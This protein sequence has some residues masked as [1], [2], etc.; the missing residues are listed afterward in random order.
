MGMRTGGALR[1]SVAEDGAQTR[2]DM[3]A[4]LDA[5]MDQGVTTL[6]GTSHV[7]PGLKPFDSVAYKAHLQEA[8][9]YCRR[10]GYPMRLY[11]GAEILCTPVI[12]RY[13]NENALPTLAG[14]NVILLEF[15]PDA[16]YREV[17]QAVQLME[18][19][20]YS[21]ILAHIE[22]YDCMYRGG[23]R[24]LKDS[25]GVMYQMNC[26]SVIDGRGFLRT[27]TIRSWLKDELID[28]VA[29]DTHHAVKRPSRMRKAYET[30]KQN[31][32][33]AYAAHLMSGD[34]LGSGE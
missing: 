19:C 8:K 29:S 11:S 34:I 3:E 24:R 2:S 14:T 16:P 32:G 4:M 21:V 18:R 10:K 12:E 27:R 5:A 28:F 25:C 20:G 26:S 6:F 13:A 30:L 15:M 23:A 7:T 33:A 31:Y 17:E 22:R 1:T 9:Q